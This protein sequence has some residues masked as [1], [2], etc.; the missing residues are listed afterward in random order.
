MIPINFATRNY[1]LAARITAGLAVACVAMLLVSVFLLVRVSAVKR[2][3]N[4][5][6]QKLREAEN[7]E[8][9]ARPVLA[10]RERIIKNL[11][12]MS[13][14]LSARA[15]SWTDMFTR[16]EAAVP[17]GVALKRIEYNP[18]DRT[19]AL[20]GAAQSPEALRNLV[21]GLER[22]QAFS[23]SHLKHQSLEKGAIIFDVVAVYQERKA[24]AADLQR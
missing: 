2:D 1:L 12:S 17:T 3:L 21:A 20:Q 23:R 18:G 9:Q 19:L 13:E 6:N 22:S 11:A 10:E 24:A 14:V 4:N 15:F 16:L 7:A 5:I 8:E